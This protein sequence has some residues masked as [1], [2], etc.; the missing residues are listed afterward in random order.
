MNAPPEEVEDYVFDGVI[1]YLCN[2]D[3]AMSLSHVRADTDTHESVPVEHGSHRRLVAGGLEVA[4][5]AEA[6]WQ[7]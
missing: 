5:Q 3:T 4:Q 2:W 7:S 6:E 1:L